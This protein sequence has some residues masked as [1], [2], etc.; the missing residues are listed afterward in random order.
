MDPDLLGP[1]E[2]PGLWTPP[3]P[4]TRIV[5]GAG[6]TLVARHERATVERIR[7]GAGE[8][9]GAVHR[10]RSLAR[11]FGVEEV[12]WWAGEL[13]EPADLVARLRDRGL[14][15]FAEEP[16]LLT[17]TTDHEPPPAEGVEVIRVDDLETFRTA[18]EVDS[19]AWGIPETARA[20]RRLTAAATW[21]HERASGRIDV[22]LAV[23]DGRP[24]GFSRLVALP[25]AGIL[26][27]GAVL[28][29]ARGRGA[30]RALVRARWDASAARGVPRL[31]TSAGAMSAPILRGLGFEPIGEVHLLHDPLL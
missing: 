8:V 13:S 21:E 14:E 16:L 7:L 30:Y 17:L 1:A 18:L 11:A 26:M 24:A 22:H 31:L 5:D 19:E 29:W 20:R 6:F 2:E 27:G 25:A 9:A 3:G 28:P 23:I 12:V 4:A 10:A 15:P